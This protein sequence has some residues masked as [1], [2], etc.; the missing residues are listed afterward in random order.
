MRCDN[1]TVIYISF[2]VSH[3]GLHWKKNKDVVLATLVS[4]HGRF[5]LYKDGDG[6]MQDQ[7]ASQVGSGLVENK[8][9]R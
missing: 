4:Q 1:A 7:A 3:A 8:V 6:G 5:A 9:I 2:A